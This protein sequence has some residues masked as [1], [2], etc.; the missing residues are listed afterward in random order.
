MNDAQQPIESTIC[1]NW[2]CVARVCVRDDNILI[3]GYRC[4][5]FDDYIGYNLPVQKNQKHQP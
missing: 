4:Q 3:G 5:L 1:R 2:A